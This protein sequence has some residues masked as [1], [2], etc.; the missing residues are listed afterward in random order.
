MLAY[1]KLAW[2]NIWRNKRRTL[3]TVSAIVFAVVLAVMMQSLNR[4]SYEIVIEQNVR[5]D[6]GYLQL[7]D[8]RYEDE[9]SLDNTFLYDASVRERVLASD[10][11]IAKILPRIQTFML[12]ANDDATRGAIVYGVDHEKEHAFNGFQ[13]HLTAGRFFSSEEHAAVL[14]EG[15]ANRLQLSVGDTLVLIGQGRF[16]MTASGLFEIVGKVQHPI[17]ALNDQAVYL[18][19]P[20]AQDLL[21]AEGRI[22]ALL[23]APERERQ[24]ESVAA[25]LRE[26]F[27]REEDELAVFTWPE[28]MP[29]LLQL[30]EF[31]LAPARFM[32]AV[33]Y[34]V[35]GFGFLG[36][37]LTSTMERL[38]EFGVLLSVGMKRGRLVSVVFLEMLFMSAIG[39]LVGVAMAWLI[40]CYLHVNP[41]A[42][43]GDAARAV[44][45]MGFEPYIRVSFDA[46]QFYM[47]A[48]YVFLVAML[49]F[50]FPLIKIF[51]LNI[52]EAARK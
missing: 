38:R 48:L 11:D 15:M 21:S 30:R 32:T 43:T 44:S 18:S 29:E 47:Q 7:Q 6:T 51:R 46:D 26:E 49:V 24:T 42:L 36:T 39:I 19:L 16:E 27:D 31:D 33:L 14:T 52:L 45:D 8:Y 25:S 10:N 5:F 41:I 4:G 17:R 23:M 9:A 50:L 22:S 13:D 28:L 20:V 3:I 12:A 1:L 40:I 37:I 2:R 35:I 34:I